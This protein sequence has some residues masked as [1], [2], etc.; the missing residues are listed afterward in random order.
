M[1][2]SPRKNFANY[3]EVPAMKL[4]TLCYQL[5][6]DSPPVTVEIEGRNGWRLL[7]SDRAIEL[8]P[9]VDYRGKEVP[10][11]PV[12]DRATIVPV[13]SQPDFAAALPREY[14]QF[15]ERTRFLGKEHGQVS[16]WDNQL[17]WAFGKECQMRFEMCEEPAPPNYPTGHLTLSEKTLLKVKRSDHE[18][19]ELLARIRYRAE[20]FHGKNSLGVYLSAFSEDTLANEER[21]HLPSHIKQQ[22]QLAKEQVAAAKLQLE[23]TKTAKVIPAK[24]VC[25]RLGCKAQTLRIYCKALTLDHKSLTEGDIVTLKNHQSG[26]R[27]RYHQKEQKREREKQ[28]SKYFEKSVA[29]MPG[30]FSHHND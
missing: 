16:P 22:R 23:V 7:A 1:P 21:A 10:E 12:F 24:Q 26:N 29:P 18:H 5:D 9:L 8:Q 6:F 11:I 15:V 3:C 30:P 14:Q 4:P 2:D 28:A 27:K 13:R 20:F 25:K 17:K 19:R